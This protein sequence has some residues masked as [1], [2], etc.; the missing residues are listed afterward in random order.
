MNKKY[1]IGIDYGTQS[2]RA[3]LVEVDTGYEVGDYEAPYPHAVMEEVLPD[4]TTKLPP[5]WALQHPED[6]L[7]CLSTVTKGVMSKYQVNPE[8][9]VGVGVDFTAC[10]ILPVDENYEPL[11]FQEKYKSNPHAYVKLWKHHAAQKYADLI[12]EEAIKRGETFPRLYGGKISSEWLIPKV[13]QVINEAP[14]IYDEAACFIE[15]GDWIVYKLTGEEKRSSCFAGYK[16]LWHKQNGYPSKDFLKALDARLE[17]L[18]D[19]KLSNDIYPLGDKAG[20]VNTVGE[21]LTGLKQGTAVAVA[22]IDAHAAVPAA[23]IAEEG[24]LLM[25]MGT[26]T[27]HMLLSKEEV[28]VP[29]IAGLVEDGI[30]PGFIGYEAG[31]ACVGDHFGWFV[32]NC[33]P[34]SYIQECKEKGMNIHALL[35]EK[36]ASKLKV[37]ESGLLALDWWNGNRSVLVDAD[38]TGLIMGCTLTT[39]PEEIYRALIEATAYGTK[40]IVDT[41]KEN[42]VKITGLYAAGGIAQK[43]AFMMQIYSDVTN[44]DIHICDSDQAVALGSAMFGAVAA[45][46]E[47]GG[48]DTIMEAVDKMSKVKEDYY[49]PSPENHKVYQELFNEY[50]TLHDYFGRG[51]ND[52][53]KRLKDIKLAS[54][55]E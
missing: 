17:S 38:L 6:Y 39:K 41:F 29:G 51:G 21:E 1:C 3:L 49:C 44:M 55:Y 40:I 46:E 2:C 15:A 25:I 27:C 26:S 13:M 28:L 35:T 12:N 7:Y 53:M 33:V 34:E 4:K 18:V 22:V 32:N 47:K 54:R 19:D 36:K 31:Q 45:G 8:D 30:L 14:E 52:V 11:C 24:K 43:N 5:D 48:Y 10:T 16:G 9:I 20:E 42:G 37:G 23:G 50:K